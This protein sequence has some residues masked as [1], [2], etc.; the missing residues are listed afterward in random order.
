ML[1]FDP[2]QRMNSGDVVRHPFFDGIDWEKLRA[3]H[4]DCAFPFF[5]SFWGIVHSSLPVPPTDAPSQP[6]TL[7][8]PLKFTTDVGFRSWDYPTQTKMYDSTG[9]LRDEW[10]DVR[11]DYWGRVIDNEWAVEQLTKSLTRDMAF[12]HIGY[13]KDYKHGEVEF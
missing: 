7:L 6:P 4:D 1:E 2:K 13:F 11:L 10:E 3:R 5:L 12:R 8:G 9:H